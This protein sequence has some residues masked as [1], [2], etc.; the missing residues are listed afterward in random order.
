MS[1]KLGYRLAMHTLSEETVKW[2]IGKVQVR[3]EVHDQ[4]LNNPD[5]ACA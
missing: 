5:I 4:C 2:G 1:T 3:V